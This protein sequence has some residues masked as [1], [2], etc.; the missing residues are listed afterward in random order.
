MSKITSSYSSRKKR[1]PGNSYHLEIV[2]QKYPV[3]SPQTVKKRDKKDCD[4]GCT[5]EQ[6]QLFSHRSDTAVEAFDNVLKSILDKYTT[7]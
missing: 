1:H 5:S 2:T 4:I 6:Y 7:M 3:S